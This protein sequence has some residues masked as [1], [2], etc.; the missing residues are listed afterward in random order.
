V[1]GFKKFLLRGNV[2][3]LAI[4]VVIGAAFGALVKAFVD[5]FITPI[6]AAF[7]GKAD[8]SKLTFTLHKSRFLYG[9]FINVLIAFLI[10]AAV[11]YFFVVVPLNRLMDRFKPAPDEPTPTRDCPHCVSSIPVIATVCAYCTRDVAT[12]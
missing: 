8:F 5:D 1:A 11:I 3:D 12:A 2:V 9:D 6:V 4:A 10:I 7:A